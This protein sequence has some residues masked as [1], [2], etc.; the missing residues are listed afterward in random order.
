MT[1]GGPETKPDGGMAETGAETT[2]GAGAGAGGGAAAC[3]G[4][5]VVETTGRD[6]DTGV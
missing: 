3:G 4:F 2:A 5:G 6:N 1:E